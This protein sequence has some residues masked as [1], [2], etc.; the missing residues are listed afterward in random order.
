MNYLT[1]KEYKE[2]GFPEIDEHEFQKLINRA[3]DVVDQTTSFYYLKNDLSKDHPIMSKNFKK[4]VAAQVAHFS[5]LG[6]TT[7]TGVN[8][9]QSVTLGRTSMSTGGRSGGGGQ[10][11]VSIVS[12][13]A[14]RYL[15]SIGLVYKGLGVRS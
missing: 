2:F 15:S 4:A 6:S 5:E 12:P 3:S 8:A 10:E 9:P 7:A 11:I 13:D 14:I 1:F